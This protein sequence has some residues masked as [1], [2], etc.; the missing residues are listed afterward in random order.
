MRLRR[1]RKKR[2]I[3]VKHSLLCTTDHHCAH[4]GRVGPKGEQIGFFTFPEEEEMK[5][6]WIYAIRRDVGRF[7]RIPGASKLCSLHFKLSDISRGLI[8]RRMSLKTSAVPSIFAWKQ[9]S[10]RKRPPPTER[11]YQQQQKERKSLQ[12]KE[13]FSVFGA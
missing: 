8:G 3:K 12:E 11:P 5:K 13:S 6:R 7:F 2:G 9:T 4:R 1:H 10:P